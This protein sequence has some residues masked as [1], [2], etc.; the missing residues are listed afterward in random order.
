MRFLF[1]DRSDL[2]YPKVEKFVHFERT[3]SSAGSYDMSTISHGLEE[4]AVLHLS[5]SNWDRAQIKQAWYRVMERETLGRA[6]NAINRTY[7]FT[8]DSAPP[9]AHLGKIKI[10]EWLNQREFDK[11]ANFNLNR[12]WHFQ[13]IK[14]LIWRYNRYKFVNLQMWHNASLSDEYFRRFSRTPKSSFLSWTYERWSMRLLHILFLI[15]K[16]VKTLG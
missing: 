5:Y 11:V 13:T 10:P 3:P 6:S 15:R 8:L 16:G 9:I 12:S 4:S 7:E 14:N 2:D 1:A